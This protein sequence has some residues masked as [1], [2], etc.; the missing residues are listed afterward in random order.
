MWVTKALGEMKAK[1][2]ITAIFFFVTLLEYLIILEKKQYHVDVDNLKETPIIYSQSNCDCKFYSKKSAWFRTFLISHRDLFSFTFAHN[3]FFLALVASSSLPDHFT[4]ADCSTMFNIFSFILL[5]WKF[6]VKCFLCVLFPLFSWF[7]PSRVTWM[8][9]FNLIHSVHSATSIIMDKKLIFTLKRYRIQYSMMKDTVSGYG[10]SLANE[11]FSI[12]FFLCL[13]LSFLFF[14]S[15]VRP[16]IISSICI[17]F[18]SFIF[19]L[20][21]DEKKKHQNDE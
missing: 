4:F 8:C 16:L 21:T 7:T 10:V 17:S 15:L 1:K 9:H 20:K 5:I 18:H 11:L 6:F 19:V 3:F 2:R 13:S 14:L 12:A